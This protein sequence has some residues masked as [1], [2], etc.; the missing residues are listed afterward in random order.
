MGILH[1]A[2]RLHNVS[3]AQDMVIGA[4]PYP[5]PSLPPPMRAVR[6]S[7]QHAPPPP[8]SSPPPSSLPPL[9]LSGWMAAAFPHPTQEARCGVL[10]VTP[11]LA[12]G[13]GKVWA[14]RASTRMVVPGLSM[15]FPC[16]QQGL[17]TE[18]H[19]PLLRARAV[20]R[21]P[22]RMPSRKLVPRAFHRRRVPVKARRLW[23]GSGTGTTFHFKR[24][25]PA[26]TG[27]SH[28]YRF[29]LPTC[30]LSGRRCSPAPCRRWRLGR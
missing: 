1:P 16:P 28:R 12:E 7:L 25:R 19:S 24:R 23:E 9:F 17:S 14:V 30:P 10:W 29:P 6:K 27:L 20:K 18:I 11:A 3:P 2:Y 8:P 15:A 22:S 5:C 21:H 13:V 26:S 4:C